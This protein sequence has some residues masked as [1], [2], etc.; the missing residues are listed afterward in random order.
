MSCS[1]S[2]AYPPPC[3]FDQLAERL[4]RPA[5][6]HA[7]KQ[8]RVVEHH[9]VVEALKASLLR[10]LGRRPHQSADHGLGGEQVAGIGRLR[11]RQDRRHVAIVELVDQRG[12]QP[13]GHVDHAAYCPVR[14]RIEHVLLVLNHERAHHAIVRV[15]GH[16]LVLAVVELPV[17]H[18]RVL[19]ADLFEP[20]LGRLAK[21]FRPLE[22]EDHG[23]VGAFRHE[24]IGAGDGH[25]ADHAVFK[26]AGQRPPADAQLVVELLSELAIMRS[27]GEQANQGVA[28]MR[29]EI[30]ELVHRLDGMEME[31]IL[32]GGD[33]P[34]DVV[35]G[36][37]DAVAALLLLQQ[38]LVFE[39]AEIRRLKTAHVNGQIACPAPFTERLPLKRFL[40][41][42]AAA[43]D[44]VEVGL[45]RGPIGPDLG[46]RRRVDAVSGL[47]LQ[48]AIL[49]K[50][51]FRIVSQ[52]LGKM[53]VLLL[54]PCEE[55][56]VGA[57]RL[58]GNGHF[59]LTL[60][61]VDAPRAVGVLGDGLVR[62]GQL[63]RP[64]AP[65]AAVELGVLLP[66][67]RFLGIDQIRPLVGRLQPKVIAL[68][69]F[70]GQEGLF[71]PEREH[72]HVALLASIDLHVLLEGE[73][74]GGRRT[75]HRQRHNKPPRSQND[76]QS[77]NFPT[78]SDSRRGRGGARPAESPGNSFTS[79]ESSHGSATSSRRKGNRGK[80]TASAVILRLGEKGCQRT[81][82]L[83]IFPEGSPR[84]GDRTGW[85]R[86]GAAAT[87]RLHSQ[88]FTKITIE[89]GSREAKALAKAP[90]REEKTGE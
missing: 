34:G 29:R 59:H 54:G 40:D 38:L 82:V 19:L 33:Q 55:D 42:Q 65:Q 22:A 30:Q 66:E 89:F 10:N 41:R 20:S 31:E 71:E 60:L 51:L 88:E 4:G 45:Q 44:L 76:P 79:T 1:A 15:V 62:Q 27:N 78:S 61:H 8:G 39:R 48:Q 50:G 64:L 26:Q 53:E 63:H 24:G 58:G 2:K 25:L 73:H 81:G 12:R 9:E 35:H 57:G 74:F 21:R 13:H 23:H 14:V 87:T 49:K 11:G 68:F 83:P 70:L 86:L 47:G 5:V 80:G 85:A 17:Y 75:R 43:E 77:N 36:R 16:H 56:T 18:A 52:Q 90:R 72:A 3:G 6:L 46:D 67:L 69:E 7:E 28:P 32:V 84:R 37:L